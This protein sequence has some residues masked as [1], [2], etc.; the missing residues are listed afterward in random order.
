[1]E[2]VKAR[3]KARAKA[4]EETARK[5]KRKQEAF[6]VKEEKRRRQDTYKAR[7]MPLDWQDC[8]SGLFFIFFFHL[9]FMLGTNYNKNVYLDKD[10]DYLAICQVCRKRHCCSKCYSNG[11]ISLWHKD[12]KMASCPFSSNKAAK[13]SESYGQ[14]MSAPGGPYVRNPYEQDDS[15]YDLV[16]IFF[17]FF[18][19]FN[20]Y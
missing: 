6:A 9:S 8:Q 14:I 18:F 3:A 5:L 15:T 12:G 20:T 17:F 4:A 19:F 10:A 1:M 2:S 13:S 7:S 16:R 11:L